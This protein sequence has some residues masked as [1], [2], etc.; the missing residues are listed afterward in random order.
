MPKSLFLDPNTAQ[1]SSFFDTE[2]SIFQ[3]SKSFLKVISPKKYPKGLFFDSKVSLK[4][5][6]LCVVEQKG[7][8]ARGEI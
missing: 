7:Q 2:V 5:F 3:K 8:E 6:F 1:E 4:T